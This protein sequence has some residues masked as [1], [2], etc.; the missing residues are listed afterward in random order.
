MPLLWGKTN[1]QT[2]GLGLSPRNSVSPLILGLFSFIGGANISK[3]GRFV[4]NLKDSF[5]FFGVDG[6]MVV[7]Q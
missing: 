1:K 3:E 7:K 6:K 2:Y 5:I 4:E